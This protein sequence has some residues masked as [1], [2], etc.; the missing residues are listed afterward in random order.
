MIN[1]QII[2]TL[3]NG[4]SGTKFLYDLFRK[5]ADDCYEQAQALL[6][7]EIGLS[8]WQP[9][10]LLS[11]IKNYSDTEKTINDAIK[12]YEKSSR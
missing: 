11:F 3:S 10:H 12:T 2:L 4:R 7:A 1:K 9:N 8:N 5:N 6:L